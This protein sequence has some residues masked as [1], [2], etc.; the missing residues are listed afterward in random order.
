MTRFLNSLV[1]TGFSVALA[2]IVLDDFRLGA[3]S[4]C[5]AGLA[6]LID[7]CRN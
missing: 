2:S 5:V 4:I 3:F 7:Y 1:F 6:A